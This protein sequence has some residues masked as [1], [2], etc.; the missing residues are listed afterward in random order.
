MSLIKKKFLFIPADW[1]LSG[2]DP[3]AARGFEEFS[4]ISLSFELFPLLFGSSHCRLKDSPK[5]PL[6][7]SSFWKRKKKKSGLAGRI[8]PQASHM[9]LPSSPLWDQLDVPPSGGQWQGTR[10]P[11]CASASSPCSQVHVCTAVSIPA[12][13][14]LPEDSSIWTNHEGRRGCSGGWR[15]KR[16]KE[17]SMSKQ[18]ERRGES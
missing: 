14:Q 8:C 6:S 13:F 10:G 7:H 12:F 18:R 11:G 5:S 3:S 2:L 16:R 15:A 17:E 9:P 4:L 1:Q